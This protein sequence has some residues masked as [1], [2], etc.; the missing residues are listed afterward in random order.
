MVFIDGAH[1]DMSVKTDVLVSIPKMIPDGLLVF[2]D[3]TADDP[4]V[5]RTVDEML[6][7]GFMA[8]DRTESLIVLKRKP[9]LA[10]S[11][12]VTGN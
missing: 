8:V 9:A 3:Y 1:D 2:H 11:R 4:A 10:G 5:V 7:D 6:A 12:T